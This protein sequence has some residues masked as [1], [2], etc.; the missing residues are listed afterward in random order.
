VPEGVFLGVQQQKRE[1]DHSLSSSVKVKNV[2]RES[3]GKWKL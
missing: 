2:C 3:F 1:A